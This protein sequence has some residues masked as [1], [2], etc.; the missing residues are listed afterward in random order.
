MEQQRTNKEIL[1]K[2]VK[3]MAIAMMLMIIGPT[4]IHFGFKV[5]NYL[6][7][8]IAVLVSISAI[9]MFLKGIKTLLKALFND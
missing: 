4:L 5:R 9:I 2:G 1:A 8:T 6:T 3:Y 7:L